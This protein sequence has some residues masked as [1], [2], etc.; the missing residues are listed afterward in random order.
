MPNSTY[1]FGTDFH[2]L[3]PEL[4][5]SDCGKLDCLFIAAPDASKR[6]GFLKNVFFQDGTPVQELEEG[7]VCP[8]YAPRYLGTPIPA[9]FLDIVPMYSQTAAA[10][11]ISWILSITGSRQASYLN[12]DALSFDYSYN[13][14][15]IRFVFPINELRNGSDFWKDGDLIIPIADTFRNDSDWDDYSIPIYVEQQVR[16]LFW[17]WKEYCSQHPDYTAP[18]TARIVRIIGNL[19]TDVQIRTLYANDKKDAATAER[20]CRAFTKATDITAKRHETISW[21][22]RKQAEYDDAY[23]IDDP[24]LHKILAEYMRIR[25]ERLEKEEKDK[26]LKAEADA[27]ALSIASQTPNDTKSG[28]LTVGDYAFTVTHSPSRKMPVKLTTSIIGQFAPEF[29]AALI[30]DTPLGKKRV[31]ISVL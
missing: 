3:L 16:L 23:R 25:S 6:P 20:V 21:K 26:Q 10:A 24:A 5:Q 2:D 22:E 31:N 12:Q 13:G 29:A 14:S 7:T 8:V 27:I 4:S 1:W 17:C 30:G 18:K 9:E 15:P 28:K 19:P 11:A